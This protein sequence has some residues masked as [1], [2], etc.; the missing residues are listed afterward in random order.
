M[1]RLLPK[2]ASRERNTQSEQRLVKGKK[3][4]YA[5]VRARAL[6]KFSGDSCGDPPVP[7]PNTAVKAANAESTWGA[8]PW[9]DRKPLIQ[10]ERIH[11]VC[12][13]FGSL[14]NVGV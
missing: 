2:G 4:F 1:N 12:V 13:L 10:E 5:V 3:S 7:M 9:E 6:R 11:D 8:A 14:S